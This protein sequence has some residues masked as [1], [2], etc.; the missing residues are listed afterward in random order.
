MI[1]NYYNISGDFKT[2][3]VTIKLPQNLY[4][5]PHETKYFSFQVPLPDDFYKLFPNGHT[6]LLA[7]TS[8]N[9]K[10]SY[11][12]LYD[13]PQQLLQENYTPLLDASIT[14]YKP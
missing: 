8:P 9:S 10:L 2:S 4:I 13:N 11:L 5:A 12:M 14:P 1:L 3:V 7:P 6:E